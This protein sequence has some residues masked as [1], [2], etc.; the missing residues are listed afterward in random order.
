MSFE[1]L[2]QGMAELHEGYTAEEKALI[3]DVLDDAEHLEDQ[4]EQEDSNLVVDIYLD[5]EFTDEMSLCFQAVITFKYESKTY[6]K[7][8]LVL[9]G[10]YSYLI[11][12]ELKEK[13]EKLAI[14]IQY[15]DLNGD[16]RK[17]FLLDLFVEFLKVCSL[18]SE[19]LKCKV[20]VWFYFSLKDLN[21]A[22]GPK[23]MKKQY[24]LKPPTIRQ[25]RS[26]SGSLKFSDYRNV[27][28]ILKDFFGL[29]KYGLLKLVQSYGLDPGSKTKL[30]AYKTN[31]EVALIEQTETF[32]DYAMN[33]VF[34]LERLPETI[35][36]TYNEAVMRECFN[37]PSSEY[38]NKYSL[39]LTIGSLV[40]RIVNKYIRVFY[41]EDSLVYQLAFLKMGMLSRMS[42]T[43]SENK[44]AFIL[45]NSFKSL[46]EL[47]VLEK[48][49]SEDWKKLKIL[50]TSKDAF[51]F[52]STQFASSKFFVDNTPNNTLDVLASIV[53][54]RTINEQP[55][56]FYFKIGLDLDIVG[57]YAG[58]L[59]TLIIPLGRPTYLAYTHNSSEN[60]RLRNFLRRY[61][62]KF[63]KDGLF[64]IVVSGKLSFSQDLIYSRVN[65]V[66]KYNNLVENYD[67]TDPDTYSPSAPLVMLR[68][69]IREGV[70]TKP[71]LDLLDKVAT[72]E[73]KKEIYDLVVDAAVFWEEDHKLDS[74]EQ[75]AQHYMEAPGSYEFNNKYIAN[76]E[77]RPVKWGYLSLKEPV[78][79]LR[80]KRSEFQALNTPQGN[81]YQNALKTFLNTLYGVMCS[82]YFNLNNVVLGDLITSS[83]RVNCWCMAKS[84]NS[85]LSVTDGVP[86]SL[87][88]VFYLKPNHKKPGLDVL[89]S[90]QNMEK[91]PS[92]KL[93]PLAGLNWEDKFKAREFSELNTLCTEHVKS[94]WKNYNY[95]FNS[96]FK[97][98]YKAIILKGCYF[99][100]AHYIFLTYNPKTKDFDDLQEKIRGFNKKAQVPF[101]NPIYSLMLFLLENPQPP[102]DKFI[103]P[104]G[105]KYQ[106]TSLLRISGW[107]KSLETVSKNKEPFSIHGINKLPGDSIVLER[108]FRINNAHF[109]LYKTADFASRIKRNYRT[110][111]VDGVK[112]KTSLFEKHLGDLGVI[113]T[114]ELMAKN[115]LKCE[116]PK[117]P[118][119]A[120]KRTSKLPKNLDET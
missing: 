63:S 52:T 97:L 47:R 112:V 46:D 101:L 15:E 115:E 20:Y 55:W 118:P 57:A 31:M 90:T 110:T 59:Q 75:L 1:Q 106:V 99:Q 113:K 56:W 74:V 12:K 58:I 85:Y 45:L 69:E 44:E 77:K 53:G 84:L 36:S 111:V 105:G 102:H 5:T 119:K 6:K 109:P 78:S 49:D 108:L 18:W 94:F 37:L 65:T 26:V 88:N 70:L 11:T 50:A 21:I 93:E 80:I 98:E 91:H 79:K 89:S 7:S 10:S 19:D 83:I 34:V 95:S 30:D 100:K 25:F 68:N 2:E 76:I 81:A 82:V 66:Q 60:L 87:T 22:F 71:I 96:E 92:L 3:D 27:T 114:F 67:H 38:F 39:P 35:C 8:F 4:A 103:I 33:D 48:A 23:N 104:N 28:F 32:I 86:F 9:D 116:E 16:S 62:H 54:G 29:E 64:K 17:V 40:S 42:K 13:Y 107:M 72:N 24:L 73:E 43:N 14:D 120:R 61:K 51:K 41:F 117:A